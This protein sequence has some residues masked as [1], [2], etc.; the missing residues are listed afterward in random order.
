MSGE[1]TEERAPTRCKSTTT[2]IFFTSHIDE[3]Q[4]VSLVTK[5]YN[6]MTT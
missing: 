3:E 6:H 4:L 2:P 1:P 5:R